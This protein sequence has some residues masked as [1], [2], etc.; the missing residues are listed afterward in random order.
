MCLV[1]HFF[2]HRKNIELNHTGWD[3][4]LE[5]KFY[6]ISCLSS[7]VIAE[8][9]VEQATGTNGWAQQKSRQQQ[10]REKRVKLKHEEMIHLKKSTSEW[11]R[12]KCGEKTVDRAVQKLPNCRFLFFF[13]PVISSDRPTTAGETSWTWFFTANHTIS[14]NFWTQATMTGCSAHVLMC[15]IKIRT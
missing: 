9:A 11:R 3:L 13:F 14:T 12:V 15:Q 5:L 2:I 4:I 8:W 7:S 6:G 10:R 1:L